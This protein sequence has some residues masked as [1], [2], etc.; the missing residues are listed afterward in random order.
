MAL[1]DEQLVELKTELDTDPKSLGY[2]GKSDPEC[3][4]LLNEVGLSEE[5]IANDT[6]L[7]HDVMDAVDADELTSVPINKLQF[8]LARMGNG[9]TTVDVSTGSPMVSQVVDIFGGGVAPNTLA[10]LNA[11]TE[12]DASRAEVLFGSGVSVLH[13]DVGRARQL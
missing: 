10:A 9:E 1:T 2:D 13:L 11:L 7:I 8:F 6:A 5:T 3:A 4:E 12:R